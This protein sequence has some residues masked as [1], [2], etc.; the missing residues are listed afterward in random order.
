MS[1][2]VKFVDFFSLFPAVVFPF[3]PSFSLF[4]S[5]SSIG[6]QQFTSAS[7]PLDRRSSHSPNPR[8]SPFFL[9]NS[10]PCH[11]DP[12][13]HDTCSIWWSLSGAVIFPFFFFLEVLF[14]RGS[15]RAEWPISDDGDPC[16]TFF[17]IRRSGSTSVGPSGA[18]FPTESK[19]LTNPKAFPLIMGILTLS[20]IYYSELPV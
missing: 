19:A 12:G 14:R 13:T 17:S 5:A 20:Q 10:G 4:P 18:I 11:T 6:F 8:G 15:T 1:Y 2:Q 9:R 7:P 3:L 16:I